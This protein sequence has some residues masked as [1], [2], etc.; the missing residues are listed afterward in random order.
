V[1]NRRTVATQ[2]SEER[3]GRL[4]PAISTAPEVGWRRWVE[5]LG[6]SDQERVA[7]FSAIVVLGF[8]TG[9]AL[10][11]GFAWLADM[12]FAQQLT[13]LDANV[14]VFVHQF[15]SPTMDVLARAVSFMGSEAIG[16]L[17]L[18]LLAFFV[19]QRRWGAASLLVLV[20]MGAQLLNDLLKD[21]YRR[22]RPEPVVGIISAQSYSFPSGHA[23]VS[24]AFYFFVAYLVWRLVHGWVQWLLVCALI[25]LVVL[26]GLSRV[27]LQAHYISDVIAGYAAGIVSDAVIIGSRA[28]STRRLRR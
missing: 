3:Q 13:Q 26:I 10:V 20:A 5:Q 16:V 9:L 2:A 12:V 8:V 23:M 27:Y 17:A 1:L 18:L 7:G 28:L 19:W 24:S 21:V 15:R 4:D 22:A 25:L 14:T 6:K 11:Y